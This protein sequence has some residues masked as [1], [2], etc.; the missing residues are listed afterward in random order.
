MTPDVQNYADYYLRRLVH[1]LE[2]PYDPD[3]F[4]ETAL[5]RLT[6]RMVLDSEVISSAD[7]RQAARREAR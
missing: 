5:S 4:G 2:K 7:A 6:N 3:R 1:S